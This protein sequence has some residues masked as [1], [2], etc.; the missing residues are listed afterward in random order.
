MLLTKT[1]KVAQIDIGRNAVVKF[2]EALTG[3]SNNDA[4]MAI[5]QE[6]S[7]KVFSEQLISRGGVADV[8]EPGAYLIA[9]FI[10]IFT[11]DNNRRPLSVAVQHI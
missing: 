3:S 1:S 11:A 8:S 6:R 9:L 2:P 10:V 5:E 4:R 7:S